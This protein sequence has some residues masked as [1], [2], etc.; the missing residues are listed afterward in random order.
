MFLLSKFLLI[1]SEK[2]YRFQGTVEGDR[3]A[4]GGK[5]ARSQSSLQA[6]SW[7]EEQISGALKRRQM[8]NIAHVEMMDLLSKSKAAS[9]EGSQKCGAPE[10]TWLSLL[11]ERHE[12]QM[13]EK[14]S[15]AKLSEEVHR[16]RVSQ[17]SAVRGEILKEV[18]MLTSKQKRGCQRLSRK[19]DG[20]E[21]QPGCCEVETNRSSSWDPEV[22]CLCLFFDYFTSPPPPND[23][24]NHSKTW[25]I[26]Q[27]VM[28]SRLFFLCFRSIR[29]T[30]NDPSVG[31][32]WCL[33]PGRETNL[34][35]K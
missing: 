7:K 33:H 17:A 24:N 23:H 11:G 28:V 2:Q 19:D 34:K 4:G 16:S 22:G 26:L 8:C 21:K 15:S 5:W 12:G 13:L 25:I 10:E 9:Q 14:T 3:T 29:K 20:L 1:L 31:S 18:L 6:L 30:K 35:L 27:S 32:K